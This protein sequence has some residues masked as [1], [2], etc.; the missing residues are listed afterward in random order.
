MAERAIQLHK[1]RAQIVNAAVLLQSEVGIR[2]TSWEAIGTRAGVSTATVYRHF[3]TLE[4]LVPACAQAAFAAGARLPTAAQLEATFSGLTT[5][6][7]RLDRVITE[8]CRCYQ[9]GEAWLD[10]CRRE[11][12]NVPALA[13]ALRTQDRALDALIAA[14]LGSRV[15]LERRRVVKAL[16]DFPFWKSLIDAGA[17]RAKAPTI[18]ADLALRLVKEPRR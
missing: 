3:P 13:D 2:K 10:A 11:A 5:P 4:S 16:V 6:A 12:P 14:A 9:R 8:S 7:K 15:P 17:P 18:I 1:T